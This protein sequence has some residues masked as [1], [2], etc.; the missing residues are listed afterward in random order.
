[1]SDTVTIP[2]KLF[3]DAALTLAGRK[4]TVRQRTPFSR[5]RSGQALAVDNW[6]AIIDLD[7]G[8]HD[9]G[10][11]MRVFCHECA[12][13]RLHFG[14]LPRGKENLP[15]GAVD[16]QWAHGIRL[17]LDP[18]LKA[19]EA[20][21]GELGDKWL[22]YADENYKQ[23]GDPTQQ[24]I[25]RKLLALA[26]WKATKQEI[27]DFANKLATKCVEDGFSEAHTKNYV[28]IKVKQRFGDPTK[29]MINPVRILDKEQ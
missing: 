20:A 25:E 1:M 29:A 2:N 26:D 17:A 9:P 22:A 6:R 23:Y 13:C 21:A 10:D 14:S 18:A 12:D 8:I 16:E 11:L 3:E 19:E 7:P 5:G 24:R 27:T 28:T 4:V 15:P